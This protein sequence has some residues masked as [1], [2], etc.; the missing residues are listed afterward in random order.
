MSLTFIGLG[1]VDNH[2]GKKL[3]SFGQS[4]EGIDQIL[5]NKVKDTLTSA[6]HSVYNTK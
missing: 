4:F 1:S 2:K 5:S 6:N 3:E